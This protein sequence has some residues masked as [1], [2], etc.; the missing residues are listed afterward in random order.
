MNNTSGDYDEKHKEIIFNSDE[1]LPSNNISKLY[2]LTIVNRSA[3][4]KD[5]NYYPQVFWDKCLYK[6]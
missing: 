6:L 2:N 3:F 4:Q 5:K 1:N